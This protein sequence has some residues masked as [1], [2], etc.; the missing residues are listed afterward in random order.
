MRRRA[1][2]RRHGRRARLSG[3][4]LLIR[5]RETGMTAHISMAE[6]ARIEADCPNQYGVDI[7]IAAVRE[8]HLRR[9]TSRRL[10]NAYDRLRARRIRR[11]RSRRIQRRRNRRRRCP[12]DSSAA[13]TDRCGE[14][15]RHRRN[16]NLPDRPP[17]RIAPCVPSIVRRGQ[18]VASGE[19]QLTLSWRLDGR[20]HTHTCS[21]GIVATSR[22]ITSLA[23]HGLPVTSNTAGA[24]VDYFAA[25]E[26]ACRLPVVRMAR[27]CGWHGASFLRGA[28]RHGPNCPEW[29]RGDPV[30][31]LIDSV[32]SPAR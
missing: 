25:A 15:A 10:R 29:M 16:E 13:T 2:H 1:L 12:M 23:D 32:T 5:L 6:I 7:A 26:E 22:T 24:L 18:D 28:H 20:T 17:Q 3:L 8:A 14:T 30:D 21:R 31:D 27:S 19:H 4:T 11:S 9:D